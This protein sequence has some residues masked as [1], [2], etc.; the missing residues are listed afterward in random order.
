[1]LRK[2]N[3]GEFI[4]GRNFKQGLLKCL[5]APEFVW[6]FRSGNSQTIEGNSEY[7]YQVMLKTQKEFPCVVMSGNGKKW[8]MFKDKFYWEDE[9]YTKDEVMALI[10]DRERKKDKKIKKAMDMVQNS[11]YKNNT[12]TK[13]PDD[14]RIFVWQRDEGRCVECGSKEKLEYDHIIPVSK[15]GSNTARNVQLLCEGCN[16]KKSDNI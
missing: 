13:I 16:R 7:E 3:K 10:L 4:R 6:F 1:M 5:L 8:W 9:E 15:G 14:V 2:D 11:E 12:R